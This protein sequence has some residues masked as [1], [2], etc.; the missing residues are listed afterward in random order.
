MV[1]V[2]IFVADTLSI[3]YKESLTFFNEVGL[4][5]ILSNYSTMLLGQNNIA[6]RL[7][8]ILFYA[9]SSI[10][11]YEITKDYF[12]NETDRLLSTVLF[13]VL[14]GVI[15][16]SLL[17]HNTI[18][19]IFCILL[20]LYYYKTYQT[21]NYFLLF[22]FLFIDNS[23]AIFYLALFFYSLRK[24]ENT[25][26]IISL[27]LFGLS[28]QIYGFDSNGKPRGHFLD[29]FTIYASIFSP[30][31]FLYYIYVMY[32]IGIKGTKTIYWYISVVALTFSLLFSFRQR[33]HIED[34]APYVVVTLPIII[35]YFLHTLRVRLPQFRQRHYNW[36]YLSL[37]LLLISVVI[38]LFNKP[39]YLLIQKPKSHFAYKYHFAYEISEKLKEKN[40]NYIT[41]N[42]QLENRLNFYGVKSGK[43]YLV[44]LNETNEYYLKI[45][46]YILEKKVLD[47]FVLK[48]NSY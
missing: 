18:I 26:L 9:L 38:I 42:Y 24:K 19:V 48:L 3:S 2:L 41:S 22:L 23:F 31:I 28:M 16:A 17:V 1:G 45:P 46:L 40:I 21:H 10:I 13:M 39:L 8:F 37:F 36:A 33:I 11:M 32:R 43:K 6:L 14:P 34:F 7:P 29:T 15:S 5:N 27:I 44:T 30:M 20:Y 25:L 35:K 47:V 12:K 4:L